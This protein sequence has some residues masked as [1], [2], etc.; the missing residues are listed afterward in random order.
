MTAVNEIFRSCSDESNLIERFIAS[1]RVFLSVDPVV[2]YTDVLL[3][4]QGLIK[5]KGKTLDIVSVKSLSAFTEN[6]GIDQADLVIIACGDVTLTEM[7]AYLRNEVDKES[8]HDCT[9]KIFG[10]NWLMVRVHVSTDDNHVMEI[11]DSKSLPG[12]AHNV[13]GVR[14]KDSSALLDYLDNMD[15][16]NCS[17]ERESGVSPPDHNLA[18]VGVKNLYTSDDLEFVE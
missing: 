18:C 9:S 13:S 2:C 4:I 17:I 11:L 14:W 7:P 1:E 16:I 8:L 15:V 5:E 3:D 12:D 6:N 10:N